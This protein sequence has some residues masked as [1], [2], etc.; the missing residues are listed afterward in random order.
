MDHSFM[1][2]VELVDR[3]WFGKE[4]RTVHGKVG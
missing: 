3:L 4:E 1:Q 2:G